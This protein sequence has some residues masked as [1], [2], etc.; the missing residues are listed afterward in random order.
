M[1]TKTGNSLDEQETIINILPSQITDR[2]NVYSTV[3]AFVNRMWKL[4][5]QYPA[6]VTVEKDDQYGTE[7]SVPKDWIKVKPKKKMSEEQKQILKE[8]LASLR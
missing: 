7:F 6:E 5:E 4:H 1:I 2:A 3:P 8:R